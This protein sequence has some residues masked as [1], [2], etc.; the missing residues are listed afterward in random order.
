[1]F[2]C[3]F[4]FLLVFLFWKK[5]TC[6]IS[7]FLAIFE[8]SFLNHVFFCFIFLDLLR[9][10]FPL[11]KCFLYLII[12]FFRSSSFH[13]FPLFCLL[14]FSRFLHLFLP[15]ILNFLFFF[16]L[17]VLMFLYVKH[18]AKKKCIF[19]DC[20]T[21][22]FFCL[23][24]FTKKT[25]FSLFPFLL[26]LFSHW[27]MFHFFCVLKK[28]FLIL[29]HSLFFILLFYSVSLLYSIFYESQKKMLLISWKNVG[30]T[31]FSVSDLLV[32]KN[33]AREKSVSLHHTRNYCSQ[34]LLSSL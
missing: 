29:F 14:L 25:T 27:F 10:M 3:G 28:W 24:F 7:L 23:L 16:L 6:K 8:P 33:N 2:L 20:S 9:N 26:S 34:S 4:S 1:M 15:L 13:L 21:T 32:L 18:C 30:K 11:Q 19:L 22:L 12:S 31:F 17:V 5:K